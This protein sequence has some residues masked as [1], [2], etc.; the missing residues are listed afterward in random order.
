MLGQSKVLI[1]AKT[2]TTPKLIKLYKAKE[3]LHTL[4]EQDAVYF[5]YYPGPKHPI[6]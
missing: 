1:R 4:V 3:D 5:C 6:V 2:T